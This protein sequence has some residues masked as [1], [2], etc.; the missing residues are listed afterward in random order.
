M[1]SVVNWMLA[2]QA[3]PPVRNALF[4]GGSQKPVPGQGLRE[5][6]PEPCNELFL[7]YGGTGGR[8]NMTGSVAGWRTPGM[9]IRKG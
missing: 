9:K 2:R 3:N 6:M 7:F 1:D 8:I 5:L 4:P